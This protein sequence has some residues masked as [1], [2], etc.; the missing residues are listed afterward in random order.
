MGVTSV[1]KYFSKEKFCAKVV[2]KKL[3]WSSE[4]PDPA[5]LYSFLS[6][7]NIMA[8]EDHEVLSLSTIY[9]PQNQE[10]KVL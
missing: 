5:Q 9:I 6:T 4:F 2:L 8:S 1:Y 3:T 7:R 10:E